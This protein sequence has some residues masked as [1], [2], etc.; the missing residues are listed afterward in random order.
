MYM[1]KQVDSKARDVDL[2]LLEEKE[3]KS[4]LA[5]VLGTEVSSSAR[6]HML[7]TT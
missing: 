4:S 2:L 3:V 1:L 6:L 7:L 5:W